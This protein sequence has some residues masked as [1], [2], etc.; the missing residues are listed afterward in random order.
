MRNRERFGRRAKWGARELCFTQVQDTLQRIAI[1][2]SQRHMRWINSRPLFLLE[3]KIPRLWRWMLEL[4]TTC[5]NLASTSWL[6]EGCNF[7][8]DFIDQSFALIP[9]ECA[10]SFGK[11]SVSC[12]F[13]RSEG[14]YQL[15]GSTQQAKP[16]R[17]SPRILL[18]PES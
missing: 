8:K 14:M 15:K 11:L 13:S 4:V 18:G 9:Y 17:N 7:L 1:P 5:T 6:S 3:G 10:H 2:I 12:S 16:K